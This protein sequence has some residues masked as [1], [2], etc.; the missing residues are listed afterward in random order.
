MTLRTDVNPN[1]TKIARFIQAE[2]NMGPA[3]KAGKKEYGRS[4]S[5]KR[6]RDPNDDGSELRN[7]DGTDSHEQPEEQQEESDYRV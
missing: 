5:G 6:K 7:G 4:W 3:T 1:R 2:P